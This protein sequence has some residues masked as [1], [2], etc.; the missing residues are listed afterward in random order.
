MST[1]KMMNVNT[2]KRML[3]TGDAICTGRTVK[4]LQSCGKVELFSIF[5][6]QSD[7]EYFVFC[8]MVTESDSAIFTA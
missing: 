6:T 1:V 5:T 8:D 4:N 2:A 3:S 7:A